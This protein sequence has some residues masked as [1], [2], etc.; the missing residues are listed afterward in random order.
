MAVEP[1]QSLPAA[2]EYSTGIAPCRTLY[3]RN[4]PDRL[5]KAK[6][7]HLLHAAFS[8]YGAVAWISAQK[9]VKLRGQAFI[10][11]EDMT[12]ATSALRKMHGS[13]FLGNVV[14]VQYAKNVSDKAAQDAPAA[15]KKR[16]LEKHGADGQLSTSSKEKDGPLRQAESAEPMDA[17][18]ST[19]ITATPQNGTQAA[20]QLPPNKILFAEHLPEDATEGAAALLS[21]LFA[22]FAGFVEVRPVPGKRDIAFVE[23]VSEENAAVALSGLQGHKLGDPPKSLVLS[24]AKR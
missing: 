21:D 7:I 17:Q 14:S 3:V 18:M 2:A 12:S 11:F 10:T 8:P 4:L 5:P 16:Q 9:T 1:Q 19:V 6:L 20:V 15:R 24:F 22:R 13:K 23:F